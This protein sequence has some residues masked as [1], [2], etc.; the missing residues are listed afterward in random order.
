MGYNFAQERIN[1]SPF[2]NAEMPVNSSFVQPPIP[3]QFQVVCLENPKLLN[4][5]LQNE[6]QKRLKIKE[7]E[8]SLRKQQA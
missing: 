5:I 1:E 7:H 2:D 6:E 4:H 3:E 8:S